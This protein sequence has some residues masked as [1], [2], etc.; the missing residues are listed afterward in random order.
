MGGKKYEIE[1]NDIIGGGIDIVK[2]KEVLLAEDKFDK[3][4]ERARIREKHKED[5]KKKTGDWLS[6]LPRALMRVGLMMMIASLTSA[7]FQ[8]LTK[9]MEKVIKKKEM[10]AVVSSKK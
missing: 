2:A 4:T 7:G 1:T 5:K 8:I 9:F 3:V 10:Q 6:K